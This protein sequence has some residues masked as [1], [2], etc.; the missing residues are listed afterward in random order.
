MAVKR[1]IRFTLR[2]KPELTFQVGHVH[3]FDWHDLYYVLTVLQKEVESNELRLEIES[4]L[5]STQ[6]VVQDNLF[7]LLS[8]IETD[9]GVRKNKVL[10]CGWVIACYGYLHGLYVPRPEDKWPHPSPLQRTKRIVVADWRD[11]LYCPVCG[12]RFQ[13]PKSVKAKDKVLIRFGVWLQR[14]MLSPH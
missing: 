7:L 14:H 3:R 6:E 9:G 11:D 12:R 13:T 8:A 2:T 10:A 1:Q 5:G 4:F